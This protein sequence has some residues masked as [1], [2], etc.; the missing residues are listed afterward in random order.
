MVHCLNFDEI[1]G[2]HNGI[3]DYCGEDNTNEFHVDL[4]EELDRLSDY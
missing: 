3:C 1:G 4:L 2:D